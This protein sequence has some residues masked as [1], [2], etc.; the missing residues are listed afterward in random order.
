S[1]QVRSVAAI[2]FDTYVVNSRQ[3]SRRGNDSTK[4]ARL[5]RR[6]RRRRGRRHRQRRR[7]QR[8][9]EPGVAARERERLLLSAG[10]RLQTAIPVHISERTALALSLLLSFFPP[11]FSGRDELSGRDGL[12][13]RERARRGIILL[14]ADGRSQDDR[15][16]SQ[17]PVSRVRDAAREC[18]LVGGER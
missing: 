10:T 5:E 8:P 12:I 3:A 6:G 4:I 18:W 7:R 13:P 1:R 15:G 9:G 17:A 16:I 14:A 11:S 2:E